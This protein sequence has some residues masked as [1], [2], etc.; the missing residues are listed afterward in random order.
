MLF[1]YEAF[2]MPLVLLF[3]PMSID[4]GCHVETPVGNNRQIYQAR[5]PCIVSL[6]KSG[7]QQDPA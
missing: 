6:L 5:P 2:R 1:Q 4:G 3:A 7:L